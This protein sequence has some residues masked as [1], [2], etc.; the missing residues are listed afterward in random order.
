MFNY[1]PG[2]NDRS[3]EILAA[4]Q[5]GAAQT[6]AD[7]MGNLGDNIGSVIASFAGA[8]AN[9][10][11]LEAKGAAYG[12]FLKS[13]GEQL[14]FDPNYLQEFLKKKPREQAMVGD[15]I[16][17]MQNVGNRLMSLNYLNRQG[18]VFNAPRATPAYGPSSN[19]SGGGY[20]NVP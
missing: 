8:Y 6:Q 18:A 19:N 4:G 15:N 20:T 12:E 10:K 9:N 1:S 14:G 7:M 3:G 2:V 11:A 13:H 17:G 5:M 16:I